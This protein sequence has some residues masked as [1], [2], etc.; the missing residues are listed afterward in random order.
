MLIETKDFDHR[1]YFVRH[2]ETLVGFHNTLVLTPK[3]KIGTT[4][5]TVVMMMVTN[6]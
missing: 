5:H 1:N 4:P 6:K 3:R 2:P